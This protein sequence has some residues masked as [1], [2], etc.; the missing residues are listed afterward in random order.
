MILNRFLEPKEVVMTRKEFMD[1]YNHVEKKP[2]NLK[3][4]RKVKRILIFILANIMM[5]NDVFASSSIDRVGLTILRKIQLA[6][7]WIFLI[8]MIVEVIKCVMK[9]NKE[10]I[11]KVIA[12]YLIAYGITFAGPF[13]FDM[14]KEM[15]IE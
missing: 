5:V 7:Y 8:M 14:I 6:A 13:M 3:L 2:I 10:A 11:P 1:W 12:G 15:F 9:N 4:N